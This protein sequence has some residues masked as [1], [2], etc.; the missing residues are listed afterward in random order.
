MLS[1]L[2]IIPFFMDISRSSAKCDQTTNLIIHYSIMII[3]VCWWH[4][5]LQP[6]KMATPKLQVILKTPPFSSNTTQKISFFLDKTTSWH[7]IIF[8]HNKKWPCI[9][10]NPYCT[11]WTFLFLMQGLW[12]PHCLWKQPCHTL[13]FIFSFSWTGISSFLHTLSYRG[14]QNC[15]LT[16]DT[17]YPCVDCSKWECYAQLCL[18]WIHMN[19]SV[20]IPVPPDYLYFSDVRFTIWTYPFLIFL[21]LLIY[22]STHAV[23]LHMLLWATPTFS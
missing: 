4:A 2:I 15:D 12:W 11:Q 14:S 3:F 1:T 18:P 9:V 16:L 21:A 17:M 10:S 20:W 13:I 19:T 5:I 6:P 23:L 7:E 22:D 8:F